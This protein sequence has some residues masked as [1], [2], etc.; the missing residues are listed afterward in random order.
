MP[1]PPQLFESVAGSMHAQ[2]GPQVIRPRAHSHPH[3]PFMHIPPCWHARPQAPQLFGS[4]L[5]LT[6]LQPGPQFII[7]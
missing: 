6:Q 3:V 2:P 5:G 7:P 1:Q 4:V